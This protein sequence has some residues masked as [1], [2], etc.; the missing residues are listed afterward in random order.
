MRRSV[1]PWEVPADDGSP[2]KPPVPVAPSNKRRKVEEQGVVATKKEEKELDRNAKK[3]IA[4]LDALIDLAKTESNIDR[5][6]T[7]KA[8]D[9][10]SKFIEE[11]SKREQ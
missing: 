2:R 1:I 8:A 4:A 10:L 11:E 9:M 3:A 7:L 6:K 5:D